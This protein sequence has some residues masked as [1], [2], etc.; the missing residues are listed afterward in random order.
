M[1]V[2]DGLLLVAGGLFAGFV[3]TLA[4]GGSVITIP[5]LIEAVGLSPVTA[6]GTN[7]VAIL[8]QN[9]VAVA[10]FQR[11]G[12][13][14]WR[15]VMPLL[16]AVLVGAAAGA[17]AGTQMDPD[18]MRKV[19]AFVIVLVALSAVFRP[20]RWLGGAENRLRE[21]LR[22]LVFLAIGFYGGFVHAGVGFLLLAGLVLGGGMD[23]V[24]GNA[25]KVAIVLAYTALAL[26]LFLLHGQVNLLAGVVLAIG[27]M[28]GAFVAARLAIRKGA[29]WIPWV[30]LVAALVAGAKM[31]FG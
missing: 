19:F 3:N 31:L 13:L 10:T 29:D 20:K 21:P 24:R 18:A 23:L 4:G 14:P 27:N 26:A 12:A 16:P 5:I 28:T 11:S 17:Y 30:L 9:V 8:L 22:T 15:A 7:R 1:T 25:A 2:V 6:N